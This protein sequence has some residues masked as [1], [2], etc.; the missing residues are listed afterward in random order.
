MAADNLDMQLEFFSFTGAKR[1]IKKLDQLIL[2]LPKSLANKGARKATRAQAKIVLE[3]AK[4]LVPIDTGELERSL[5]VKARKRSRRN[6]GTV[7]HAVTTGQQLFVDDQ[8]YGAFVEL[9]T[10]K[11]EADPFLRPA[12]WGNQ[13]RKWQVFINVLR[14]WLKNDAPQAAEKA[15]VD[16]GD[17]LDDL[18]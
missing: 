10:Q 12:L 5:K 18:E 14:A 4:A 15:G 8:F 3:D 1:D 13:A 9:G 6:K 17:V 2:A 16:I 7:G 11:K